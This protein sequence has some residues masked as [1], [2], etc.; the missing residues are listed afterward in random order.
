LNDLIPDGH[1]VSWIYD[2][3][4]EL[5]F[6]VCANKEVFVSGLRNYDMAIRIGYAG[7]AVKESNTT[8]NINNVVKQIC[9]Q[10]EI[11]NVL[12]L[13]NYSAML[14]VRKILVGRKIL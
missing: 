5:I 6:K 9:A 3:N 2:T 13:P 1:D 11:T 10:N 4:Q 8:S 14:Q 7:V 12:V